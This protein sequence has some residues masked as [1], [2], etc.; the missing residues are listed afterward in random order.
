VQQARVKNY[1]MGYG[2]GHVNWNRK[3]YE[4]QIRVLK[5]GKRGVPPAAAPQGG[6]SRIWAR[7]NKDEAKERTARTKTGGESSTWNIS[8][9]E[10]NNMMN[11]KIE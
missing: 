7:Q 5:Q 11:G 1:K 10:L 8:K 3:E 4:Q 9:W 6:N 2:T